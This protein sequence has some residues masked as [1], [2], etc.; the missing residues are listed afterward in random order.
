MSKQFHTRSENIPKL[1]TCC[2]LLYVNLLWVSNSHSAR[3][4][5]SKEAPKEAS[6]CHSYSWPCPG[7]PWEEAGLFRETWQLGQRGKLMDCEKHLLLKKIREQTPPTN[8]SW[9]GQGET[10]WVYLPPRRIILY[11]N[12]SNREPQCT[13][14]VQRHVRK[15][16]PVTSSRTRFN[17]GNHWDS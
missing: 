3:H 12:I 14:R 11:S 17:S 2:H 10:A 1:W 6:M 16:T 15:T 5:G 4:C 13:V 9:V 7:L 8:K